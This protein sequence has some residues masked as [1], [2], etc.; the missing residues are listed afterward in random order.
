MFETEKLKSAASWKAVL[1]TENQ[2]QSEKNA[3]MVGWKLDFPSFRKSLGRII[4]VFPEVCQCAQNSKLVE[5]QAS[6]LRQNTVRS[7][8][9]FL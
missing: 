4:I 3:G 6:D 9:F 7:L 5:P 1:P 8:C 2:K